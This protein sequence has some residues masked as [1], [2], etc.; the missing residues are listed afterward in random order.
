MEMTEI[1]TLRTGQF[2]SRGGK[3]NWTNKKILEQK[4]LSK[5]WKKFLSISQIN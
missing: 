2:F 5:I 1:V 3:W 4:E